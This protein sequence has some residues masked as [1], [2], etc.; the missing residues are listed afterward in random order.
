MENLSGFC[1]LFHSC[2][3]GILET[4]YCVLG[5]RGFRDYKASQPPGGWSSSEEETRRRN[6]NI[7]KSIIASE[8]WNWAG[9]CFMLTEDEAYASMIN[10]SL[11]F[12]R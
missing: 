3:S 1:F 2:I 11:D 12:I 5:R 9:I 10:F 8:L 7:K 4:F 6:N